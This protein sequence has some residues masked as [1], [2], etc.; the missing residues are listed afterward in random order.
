MVTGGLLKRKLHLVIPPS[1]TKSYLLKNLAVKCSRHG[2]LI[3]VSEVALYFV[4]YVQMSLM[5]LLSR[6]RNLCPT[7][8]SNVDILC[9]YTQRS[10]ERF[11]RVNIFPPQLL[12]PGYFTVEDLWRTSVL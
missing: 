7:N 4:A 9:V 2:S 6:S 11:V 10:L 12:P 8:R 3:H 1:H 5:L